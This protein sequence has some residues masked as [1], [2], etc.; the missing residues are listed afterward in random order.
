MKT[1]PRDA[2]IQEHAP[3]V[4]VPSFGELAP[5]E[6][7]GHRYLA[8]R[9][10]VFLE[11]RRPWLHLVWPMHEQDAIAP[12]LPYGE[13]GQRIT[14]SFKLQRELLQRFLEEAKRVAP[15]EHAAWILWDARAQQLKYFDLDIQSFGSGEV[16]Y[17]RPELEPH[18]SLAVDLHSHGAAAAFFSST[19]DADDAGEV[20]IAAVVGSLADGAEPT[21]ALRLCALGIYIDLPSPKGL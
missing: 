4:M 18:E 15:F 2:I 20:K 19:D 16:V 3:M 9:P 17:K 12:P 7:A 1:D 5:L 8:S 21:W 14:L 6:H 13:L 10:G 11:L